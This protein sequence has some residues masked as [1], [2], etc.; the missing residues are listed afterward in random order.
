MLSS[1]MVPLAIIMGVFIP[2]TLSNVLQ[3][4]CLK[5]H[6]CV[7]EKAPLIKIKLVITI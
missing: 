3:I 1:I 4:F 7:L 5:S 6:F 2:T